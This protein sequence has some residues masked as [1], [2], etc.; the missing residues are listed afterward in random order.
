MPLLL[1]LL[2]DDITFRIWEAA[3]ALGEIGP[4]AAAALPGLRKHLTHGY[5]WVRVHCAAA[6]W[7]IAGEAETSAVLETLL[8]AWAQNGAT[9]NH[10]LACLNRMGPAARPAL[11][12]LRAELCLP[13]RGGRFASIANDE[14][15]QRLAGDLVR[16]LA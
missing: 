10:V 12:Q 16:R 5:E 13:R 11:P 8:Q 14:E 3:D 15:L 6:I 4:P 9:A 7:E 2:D 1:G